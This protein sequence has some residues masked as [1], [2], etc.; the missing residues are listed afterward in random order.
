MTV[1]GAGGGARTATAA[2]R[3]LAD[4]ATIWCSLVAQPVSVSTAA[5]IAAVNAVVAA[6]LAAG[7]VVFKCGSPFVV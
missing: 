4:A 1:G 2:G 6:T 3:G 7:F 5:D